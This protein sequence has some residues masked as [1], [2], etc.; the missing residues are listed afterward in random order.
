MQEDTT[1]LGSPSKRDLAKTLTSGVG[2][3]KEEWKPLTKA[4]HKGQHQ[5]R[6]VCLPARSTVVVL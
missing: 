1:R 4:F 2:F 3:K 5:W 6:K